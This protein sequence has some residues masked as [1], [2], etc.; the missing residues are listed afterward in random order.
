MS[1]LHT[2]YTK[3][4]NSLVYILA[5]LLAV[6]VVTSVAVGATATDIIAGAKDI[7]SGNT[8]TAEARILLFVRLPRTAAAVLAGAALAVSGVL[9]QGVLN[10]AL[11][12]ASTIG[13]NA[14]AGFFI[15]LCTAFA[16]ASSSILPFA[17]F[18]GAVTAALLIYYIAVKTGAGRA[19]IV[20]A[21]VAISS[22]L[23]AG[24]N[25]IKLFFPDSI[26][27]TGNFF[28]GGFA[29][30]TLSDLK[31]AV[32]FIIAGLIM[33]M[34]SGRALSI[35]SL[36]DE[37]AKSLGANVKGIRFTLILI[38]ALL[39]GAAVSFGGLIS[40]VGLIVPHAARSRCKGNQTLLLAVSAIGGALLVTIC[41]TISR[42]VFSP[43]ELPMGILLSLLGGPFFIYLLLHQKK[44]RIYV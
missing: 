1:I 44:V 21:G 18:F 37:P 10:N 30:V 23:T 32:Y 8:Q 11:A 24:S 38:A 12:S 20:L 9:L 31:I 5:A 25:T 17:A 42:V 14:G 19:T 27:A 39:A 13:V 15:L 16:P 3:Q 26:T 40:F 43:Y 4:H 33:A 34:F 7:F 29:G 22:M 6:S 28:I 41:D 36:G 35:L 2:S